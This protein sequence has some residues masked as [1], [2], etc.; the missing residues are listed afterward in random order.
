MAEVRYPDVTLV[1]QGPVNFNGLLSA[2]GN[3][4]MQS[5]E[6]RLDFM[7]A[8]EYYKTLF[9]KIIL[10]T[11][12]EQVDEEIRSFCESHNIMLVHQTQDIGD[13]EKKYNI[14]YQAM[15]TLL[16]LQNVST[17]YTLKHRTDE[18]Y[19]NLDKLVDLF[20]EDD[21]KWVSGSTIFSAKSRQLFHAADHLYIAKTDKLIKVMELTLKNVRLNEF[22]RN[23]EKEP[24]PEV[25]FTRNFIAISG[26]NPCHSV[27][28]EM[29]L[30]YFNFVNDRELFPYVVKFNTIDKIYTRLEDR[31]GFWGEFNTMEDILNKNGMHI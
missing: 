4:I 19:S 15:S 31:E 7:P 2:Y 28:D 10:S 1:L 22:D 27:H 16:G 29:M 12:T 30:K 21:E 23:A 8:I 6:D 5:G 26:D 9:A 14:T 13:L 17:K 18:R 24:A 3:Q 25:T 11:Y 20:L